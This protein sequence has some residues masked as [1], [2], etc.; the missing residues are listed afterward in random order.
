MNQTI[1]INIS[2][3]VFHIDDNAYEK[4]KDYLSKVDSIFSNQERGREIIFNI[5]SRIAELLNE[6]ISAEQNVVDEKM[7]DE[8]ISIMGLPKDFSEEEFQQQPDKEQ[9]APIKN[10]YYKRSRRL[11]R[12]TDSRVFGGVCSGLAHYF[13]SDK[14]L[15]RVIF[16][17]LFIITS[18]VALPAYLILWIAVPKAQS[19]AQRLEMRGEPINVDNIGKSVNS[20]T[21]EQ[22]KQYGNSYRTPNQTRHTAGNNGG[23]ILEKIFGSIFIA[24][25]FLSLFGLIMGIFAS[26]K[27]L[28]F[29]PGFFPEMNNQLLFDHIFSSEFISTLMISTL[30]ILGMPILLIIYGGTKM[31]FNYTSNN[32]SVV[33]SALGIW[34]IAIIVAVSTIIGAV[35]G[36]KNEASAIDQNILTTQTDTLFICIDEEAYQKY[37]A[38][39]FE[40]NNIKVLEINGKEI[41]VANPELSIEKSGSSS[42]ELNI[43]KSSKGNNLKSAKKSAEKIDFNYTIEGSK[44]VLNP[45]F[46]IEEKGKWRN[47]KCRVD[48]E[49]PDGKIIFLDESILPIIHNINNASN[50]WVGDMVNHYWVMKPEGL[51]FL[52]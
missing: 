46:T 15:M 18:G 10:N 7:I 1:T 8:I 13:N 50:M 29:L 44:L 11:Y 6:R 3:I 40:I 9:E 33:L 32:K 4:L 12:D 39:K 19:T 48:L 27:V 34:V 41:L 38:S 24:I 51:T 45:Y 43:K 20:N 36:F 30:I 49:I 14:V 52:K 31:L 26:S 42:C 2:G 17:V 35:D 37:S 47:Q 22:G 21:T 16:V 28:G 23:N 5:E 25:G